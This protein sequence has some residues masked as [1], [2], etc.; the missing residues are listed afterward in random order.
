MSSFLAG[1]SVST[2][3][4]YQLSANIDNKLADKV[5]TRNLALRCDQAAMRQ[6][7]LIKDF[8]YLLCAIFFHSCYEKNTL[9]TSD[10]IF[11]L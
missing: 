2:A 1:A 4:L 7:I 3:D 8:L 10:Q 11:Y 9:K 5:V 6:K